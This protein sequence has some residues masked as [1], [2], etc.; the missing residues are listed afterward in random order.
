MP[1]FHVREM[2]DQDLEYVLEW[3]NHPDIRRF[4]YSQQEIGKEEH[5]TWF[6]KASI[7]PTKK[8]L[9]FEVD[10]EPVGFVNFS[11]IR[12]GNIA[13]WGFYLAPYAAKGT[14]AALGKT[15]LDY[16][17]NDLGLH[18]V[19][20]EALSYNQK[21]IRFHQ[22]MGFEMEGVLRDQFFDGQDY[23]SIHCFGLLHSEW[24][25]LQVD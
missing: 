2:C 3:R 8:L 14:G 22:K 25:N 11:S 9:I 21:S 5:Y 4:M 19:C 24:P 20:G 10:K 13:D 18:K 15:A 16:A 1:R 17:F 6:S 12:T 23:H 7:D